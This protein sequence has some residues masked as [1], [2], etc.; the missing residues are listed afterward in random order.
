VKN[1]VVLIVSCIV[2][3]TTTVQ[4]QII[5]YATFG[6]SFPLGGYTSD[7]DIFRLQ[8]SNTS[9]ASVLDVKDHYL[10]YGRGIDLDAGIF[11]PLMENIEAQVGLSFTGGAPNT[12][13]EIKTTA[14]TTVTQ[15]VYNYHHSLLGIK[16]IA[17]P[18]F[19][20]V[21]LFDAYLGIG[22][23]LL[24]SFSSDEHTRTTT[25]GPLTTTVDDENSDTFT[26]PV[27]AFIG[28]A[29]LEYPVTGKLSFIADIS[30]EQMRVK[31]TESSNKDQFDAAERNHIKD[32]TNDPAPVKIP[33]SNLGISL[34]VRFPLM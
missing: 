5:P 10:N 23:G 34:G 32:D 28:K 20:V 3:Y 26:R 8:E 24:L 6:Y 9:N 2:V 18:R 13:V 4:A 29:G 19:R 22:V 16:A 15:D 17:L 30:F 31:I 25:V 7:N 27:L 33:A 11:L 12:E 1:I 14:G 21:E